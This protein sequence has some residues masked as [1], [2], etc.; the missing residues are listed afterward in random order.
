[1]S[2]STKKVTSLTILAKKLHYEYFAGTSTAWKMS[3][4]RVFLVRVFPHLDWI[5]RDTE[6]YSLRFQ[7]ECGKI[8]TRKT[9]NTDTFYAVLDTPLLMIGD[10]KNLE[11][12]LEPIQAIRLKDNFVWDVTR[13]KHRSRVLCLSILFEFNFDMKSFLI[14]ISWQMYQIKAYQFQTDRFITWN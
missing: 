4:L 10:I 9:P 7:S 5:R 13:L 1:M 11:K 14:K 3:V 2:F 8:W 12:C 6:R